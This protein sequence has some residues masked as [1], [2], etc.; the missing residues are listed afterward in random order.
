MTCTPARLTKF[1][2]MIRIS[3]KFRRH[4]LADVKAYTAKKYRDKKRREQE[5]LDYPCSMKVRKQ[6]MEDW[7]HKYTYAHHITLTFPVTIKSE[8]V[9][10][11]KLSNLIQRVNKELYGKHAVK[12]AENSVSVVF[13]MEEHVSGGLHVHCLFQKPCTKDHCQLKMRGEMLPKL[14]EEHWKKVTHAQQMD[15]VGV[16]GMDP[17]YDPI[18]YALKDIYCHPERV[19]LD[20][21][22]PHKK[23]PIKAN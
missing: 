19:I 12:Y 21:F 22:H 8:S 18:E 17:E 14:V 20:Y 7:L 13:V 23:E 2:D 5:E 1:K 16:D 15:F 6:S 10:E 11:A 9:V 3:E 4:L